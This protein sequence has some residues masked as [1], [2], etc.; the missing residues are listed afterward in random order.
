MPGG[1]AVQRSH[2]ESDLSTKMYGLI[3]Q[4]KETLLP[5]K[6]I[7]QSFWVTL[8]F[9]SFKRMAKDRERMHYLT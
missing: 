6:V 3:R 1:G 5:L 2:S 9:G 7:A 4:M 8:R